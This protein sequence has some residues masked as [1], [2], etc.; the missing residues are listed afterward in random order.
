MIKLCLIRKAVLALT[1]DR[2]ISWLFAETNV[3]G[4]AT[5]SEPK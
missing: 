4:A 5:N 1:V 2:F 3:E